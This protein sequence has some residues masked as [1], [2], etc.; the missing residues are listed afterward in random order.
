MIAHKNIYSLFMGAALFF[1]TT[2]AQAG[3]VV[4]GATRVIYPQGNK[5][6]SLAVTNTDEKAIF[7]IQSWITDS[8]EKKS[9]DFVVTP[10]LFKLLPKK[11][12]TLRMIYVGTNPLPSD[13]ES[14]YYLNA[15]AIPAVSEEAQKSN[16]LQIATQ[17][18]IKLFFRPQGLPTASADAPASLRCN[19]ERGMLKVSNPS[20][21]FVTMVNLQIGKTKIA[22]MMVP[23]LT[24]ESVDV[25]NLAGN[26]VFQSIN[27]YGSQTKPSICPT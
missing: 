5:Q 17:S 23:P 3:G 22:N 11:E 26:V 9:S 19:I 14:V 2:A 15:K 6:V 4:L 13:R 12:N 20:P 1:I 8:A 27:D 18:V 10:P 25:G 7:L 16:T 21:Y 24:T